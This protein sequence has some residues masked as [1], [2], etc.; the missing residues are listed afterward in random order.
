MNVQLGRGSARDVE[1]VS[2]LA[3]GD[4]VV[5]SDVSAWGSVARVRLK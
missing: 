2:G 5:V 3:A 1:V 4:R